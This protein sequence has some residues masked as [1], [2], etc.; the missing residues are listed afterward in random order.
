MPRQ[1]A[2][3]LCTSFVLFLLRL[4][5]RGSAGVS[6]AV[7]IPSLWMLAI[8]S[9]PLG[10]WFGTVAQAEAGSG[11]DR[12]LLTGL[13]VAGIA[14]LVRRRF[15]W[16]G[17]LR[18]HG[19]LVALLVYMF[20]STLWSDIT[21]I[22]IR[23]WAREAIVVI[24]ALVV[25][26]EAN[27]RQ[28]LESVLRRSAYVLIPFSLL[29]VKYYPA[30]G[31]DYARWSGSQ[32]WIGVTLQKNTL[33]RLCLVSGFF[34]LWALYRRWREVQ[35][36]GD[37]HRWWPDLSVLGIALFLLRGS[38][39][40]Y[41]A[42]S[43]GTLALGVFA[44]AVLAWF[45][46]VRVPVPLLGLLV[47]VVVLIGFGVAAPFLGGSNLASVSSAFGRDE[48]LT[49]RTET[50]SDLVLTVKRQPLLGAGFGSFWTTARR[51]Y[52][53]MSHGHNGYLDILLEL[54]AV[55]LALFGAWLLS[56]ARRLHSSL[57]ANY[58]WSSLAICFLLMAVV[59][60]ATESALSSLAEQMTAV[61]ALASLVVP[62]ESI[63]ASSR[64]R[65]GLRLHVPSQRPAGETAAQPG[66]PENRRQLRLLSRG[67][68]QRRRRPGTRHGGQ[69]PS[70]TQA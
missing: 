34:L 63:P 68:G 64:S 28:A 51:E 52:Y 67:G 36:T 61:L 22:A 65:L 12:L 3:L 30:L 21:V 18:R 13:S 59:Y 17:T 2:L 70:G 8:A 58:D 47:L 38:E 33:G 10:I 15:D 55:G 57:P 11:L 9:K 20:L 39:N 62:Y 69:S 14:V 54:G 41:S 49:G 32:M 7:W 53:E 25:L 66:L 42:T 31:V 26:S 50:W 44:F 4:E 48:T 24:M 46:K 43:M 37:R 5:R 40:A 1:L 45:R 56:C 19:W 29:L 60:N 16:A 23:R 6:A 27:P 35:P